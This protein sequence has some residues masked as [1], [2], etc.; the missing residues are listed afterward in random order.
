MLSRMGGHKMGVAKSASPVIVRIPTKPVTGLTAGAWLVGL[1]R[2]VDDVRNE[3][4]DG[5]VSLSLYWPR[6]QKAL[7]NDDNDN[8]VFNPVFKNKDGSDG[9]DYARGVM[10]AQ[11]RQLADRGLTLVTGS[12]NG[13]LVSFLKKLLF[14]VRATALWCLG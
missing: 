2:I 12:G 1:Q 6:M 9:Y 3:S 11:L 10:A 5:V 4:K 14:P 7:F 8:P 13:A